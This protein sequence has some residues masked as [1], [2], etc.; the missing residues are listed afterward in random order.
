MYTSPKF[1]SNTSRSSDENPLPPAP[2]Y[3]QRAT[4][5]PNIINNSPWL[6][7][8]K[9]NFGIHRFLTYPFTFEEDTKLKRVDLANSGL[10]LS[11]CRQLLVCYFCSGE[12]EISRLTPDLSGDE[13]DAKHQELSP[14]CPLFIES[15][16][17]VPLV[18]SHCTNYK[19][20]A[21]RLYSLLL[22]PWSAPVS[23]YD[24]AHFGFSYTNN[25]D[26]VRCTFCR[27]EVRGWE[28]SD[29][30]VDEHRRW[31]PRCP[32]LVLQEAVGNVPIGD[33]IFALNAAD[34]CF[35]GS[36][37][38]SIMRCKNK[39]ILPSILKQKLQSPI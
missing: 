32:F 5:L 24:L 13:I 27:L 10:Y 33:E 11:K 4:T 14:Q 7:R 34:Y 8:L 30:A 38:S 17:N 18:P 20:E 22:V 23:I 12:I 16:E 26:N 9:L 19:F 31:N 35:S 6:Q 15:T 37:I 39:F 28:P 21:F 29:T 36:G 1:S 2:L 25:E 3:P